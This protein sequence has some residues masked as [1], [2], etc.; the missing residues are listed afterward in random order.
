MHE[1]PLYIGFRWVSGE[2]QLDLANV[3][4]KK[5]INLLAARVNEIDPERMLNREVIVH[6]RNTWLARGAVAAL[7][8][9]AMIAAVGLSAI[10]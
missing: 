2:E 5:R 8:I 3:D 10:I 9:F 7:L 4:F 6:R 1:V